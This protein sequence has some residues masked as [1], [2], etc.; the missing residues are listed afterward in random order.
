M[1]N[2][3]EAP[4]GVPLA[5]AAASAVVAV[6]PFS[7]A[8]STPLVPVPV[9]LESEVA[10][11]GTDETGAVEDP[12][13]P[14]A[15]ALERDDD[16][17]EDNDVSIEIPEE[18]GERHAPFVVAASLSDA[19]SFSLPR[20]QFASESP[21]HSPTVTPLNPESFIV[22]SIKPVSSV[23]VNSWISCAMARNLSL[24]GSAPVTAAE[25]ISLD[26]SILSA[27]ARL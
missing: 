14:L 26:P 20:Y 7:S 16:E 10:V 5:A 24:L 27:V 2:T 12:T 9:A 23:A 17:D 19:V 22:F 21:K 11:V 15:V 13:A 18:S 3:E 6:A 25:K 4:L 8:G 1:R